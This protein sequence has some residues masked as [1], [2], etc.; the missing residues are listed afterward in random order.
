MTFWRS[1]NESDQSVKAAMGQEAASPPLR[2]FD[3]C[4]LAETRCCGRFDSVKLP[5]G[6][7]IS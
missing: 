4:S 3:S 1:E 6:V 2:R 5:G 7:A